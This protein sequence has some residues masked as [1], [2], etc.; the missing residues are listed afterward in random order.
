MPLGR[1]NLLH[2]AALVLDPD[3][4]LVLLGLAL[5]D[6]ALLALVSLLVL[7]FLLALALCSCSCSSF[8]FDDVQRRVGNC[9][10]L[11]DPLL[12]HISHPHP[13]FLEP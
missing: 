13:S 2:S 4:G 7:L 3:I 10:L 9:H 8:G 12:E 11:L 5:L 1:W 6:L